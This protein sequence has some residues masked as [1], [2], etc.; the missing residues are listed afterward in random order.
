MPLIPKYV[1]KS[2]ASIQLELTLRAG[3]RDKLQSFCRR[4]GSHGEVDCW[5]DY[6]LSLHLVLL[7]QIQQIS[8]RRPNRAQ[9]GRFF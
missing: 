4:R 6:A 5:R 2:T 8:S 1:C 9:E 3:F 7:E